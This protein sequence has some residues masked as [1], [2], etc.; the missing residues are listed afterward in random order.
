MLRHRALILVMS[1]AGGACLFVGSDHVLAAGPSFTQ[2]LNTASQFWRAADGRRLQG[3]YD[4]A[5]KAYQKSL[6]ILSQA[7]LFGI[8]G[9]NTTMAM[10][11]QQ[12]IELCK[13]MPI[14][15]KTLKDGVWEGQA[16]GYAGLMTVEVTLKGGKITEFKVKSN[17]E[18]KPRNALQVVPALIVKKQTPSVEAVTGATI[19]SYCVMSATQRALVQAKP[20][21]KPKDK[22]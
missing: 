11:P 20:A 8:P 7:T 6:E 13:A 1:I 9:K 18:S 12:M 2:A 21:E 14:D 17:K 22:P 16:Q 3:K 19:S 4:D 15:V 10:A 5:I